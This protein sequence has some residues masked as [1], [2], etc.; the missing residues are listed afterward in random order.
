MSRNG[1]IQ[2]NLD[3]AS[4]IPLRVD[5]FTSGRCDDTGSP[6]LGDRLDAPVAEIDTGF[7]AVRDTGRG[8]DLH[9]HAGERVLNVGRQILGKGR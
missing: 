2:R 7:V 5:P 3:P 6:D 4:R 9:S 1:Q 8:H